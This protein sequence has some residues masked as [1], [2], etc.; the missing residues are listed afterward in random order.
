MLYPL[1]STMRVMDRLPRSLPLL[2]LHLLLDS[3][4]NEPTMWACMP[5]DPNPLASC[6]M[7]ASCKFKLRM[8]QK[9]FLRVKER[10][11][12]FLL[13]PWVGAACFQRYRSGRS[14]IGWHIAWDFLS[15]WHGFGPMECIKRYYFG[16]GF[17]G[18]CRGKLR[19]TLHGEA[20]K[21]NIKWASL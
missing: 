2:H 10:C 17:T 3:S 8:L 7:H 18:S 1:G 6:F 19:Q 4:R 12:S 9:L 16:F 11:P 20:K 14:P 15:E 21:E 5:W 13:E